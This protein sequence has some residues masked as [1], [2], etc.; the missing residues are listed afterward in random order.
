MQLLHMPESLSL[1][2]LQLPSAGH[3][4]SLTAVLPG[5]G[6]AGLD[7]QAVLARQL[8]GPSAESALSGGV[9]VAAEGDP[10]QQETDD[11]L[12]AAADSA[13]LALHGAVPQVPVAPFGHAIG[14]RD[15]RAASAG[16][17]AERSVVEEASDARS[18]GPLPIGAQDTLEGAAD[19]AGHD[20]R[21]AG[22]LGGE[23]ESGEMPATAAVRTE[24]PLHNVLE[25][26]AEFAASPAAQVSAAHPLDEPVAFGRRG[27]AN[28][29]G[30]RVLWM[31]SNNRQV[32]ELRVDPPHLGPVEV[33]LSIEGEQASVTLIAAHAGVREAL[34]SSIPRLQDMIHAIGLELGNVT[35]GG[36]THAGHQEQAGDRSQRQGPARSE[37][38]QALAGSASRTWSP[39]TVGIGLVDTYA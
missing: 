27:F 3:E 1:R 29:L 22:E 17:A 30:E 2:T 26:K 6:D 23:R 31:A 35:V 14:G 33:R 19:I 18:A 37:S 20:G 25:R 36:E 4:A 24:F 12:V 21:F 15:V 16:S 11:P 8:G 7:F 10:V 34:Q 39:R 5:S 9:D 28:D 32:A 38:E 13:A